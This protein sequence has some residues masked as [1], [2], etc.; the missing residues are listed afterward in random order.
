MGNNMPK[1]IALASLY[2]PLEFLENRIANL[3]QCDMSGVMV[4]W[5]DVSPERTW[6]QV[7]EIVKKC[8]F[9]YKI[10]HNKKRQTLYWA[11]SWIISQSRN[12]GIWP[13]YFCNTNVDDINRPEY[14]RI[15]SSYLDNQPDKHIVC[16][17]WLNTNVKGQHTW[18]PKHDSLSEVDPQLTLGHFPMW[19]ASLHDTVGS[20]DPRMVAIGDADFWSRIKNKHGK[21]VIG[22]INRTLACYLS[23]QNNLYYRAV[24]PNGFSGEAWDR[25]LMME[26]DKKEKRNTL[27]ANRRAQEGKRQKRRGIKK[28]RRK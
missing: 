6:K 5:L 7:K 21:K 8:E 20:F 25:G 11:W 16:C 27:I 12:D 9:S 19:R 17:N 18:P 4:W 14:F 1:I 13:K 26:R 3:N 28:G 22:K 15:M 23:H 2:E 10:S 24:G